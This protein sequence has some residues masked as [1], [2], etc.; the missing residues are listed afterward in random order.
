M[1]FENNYKEPLPTQLIIDLSDTGDVFD[2]Q[3]A[4]NGYAR[5]MLLRRRSESGVSIYRVQN[6]SN[7]SNLEIYLSKG[8]LSEL[9]KIGLPEDMLA[10]FAEYLKDRPQENEFDCASFAHH[11]MGINYSYASSEWKANLKHAGY[12]SFE[13]DHYTEELLAPGDMV[14]V[15][16]RTSG[17]I[18]NVKHFMIYLG[19]GLYISKYG[20][21]NDICVCSRDEMLKCYDSNMSVVY[22]NGERKAAVEWSY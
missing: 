12:N 22:L 21:G 11:M 4:P 10:R 15:G 5:S 19:Q 8:N 7:I 14:C 2:N 17:G 6:L 13:Y 20:N 18:I 9:M 1:G 16:V 3:K